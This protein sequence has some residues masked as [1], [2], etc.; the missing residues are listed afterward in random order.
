MNRARFD[1]LIMLVLGCAVFILLGSVLERTSA[2]SMVD[3]K[4]V[5]CGA[6]CMLE[7]CDPY[8]PSE[9]EH[10]YLREA[11]GHSFDPNGV[12]QGVTMYIYLPTA[13]IF[14]APFAMLTWGP[15]HVLWMILTGSSFIFA[16]FLMW[17][18]ASSHA[19]VISGILICVFLAGSELLIEVGNVAGIVVSLCAIAAW[20]FVRA[21]FALIGV[22][23][24]ALCLAVKP[25][26]AGLVWLYFLLAG[27]V[28]RKRALQTLVATVVLGLP[29][30]L[31]VSHV[32][33]NWAQEM[34]L[35]LEEESA[36]GS[37]S[38][39]G[40]DGLKPL[41]HGAQLIS[42]Q[43]A[44]SVFRDDP[45]VYNPLSYLVCGALLIVWSLATLRSRFSPSN[46][47]LALAA[48]SALSM[49]PTYH[50]Q[51]D[52]RLLLLT[53][54][55]FAILWAEGGVIKWLAFAVTGA[56]ALLTGDI[57]LQLLAIFADRLHLPKEGLSGQILTLVLARPAPLILLAVST[58]YLWIY[59]RRASVRAVPLGT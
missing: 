47:W 25:H 6:R 17:D 1:G 9:L 5:Y 35:N 53:F 36:H 24:L 34:R 45:R 28:Y 3:F 37:I 18:L 41:T 16:A 42:L 54:P 57:P 21:R 49:L 56:A 50:R 2:V 15:A 20:C 52:T 26:D 14:T 7:H 8:K 58:F 13:F 23:C 4:T 43:T 40:P 27:G 39:P 33:P 22:L 46:A 12:R 48:I 30:V 11:G 10:I 32:A 19:P 38:D 51:Q 29:T 55:A 44:I 31:W 59:V